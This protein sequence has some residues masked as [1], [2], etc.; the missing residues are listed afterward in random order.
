MTRH[1]GGEF[2]GNMLLIA[3]NVSFVVVATKIIA[4]IV[5][6]FRGRWRRMGIS[7]A[8]SGVAGLGGKGRACER[9]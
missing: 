4:R 9:A 7:I 3:S 2:W 5:C 1:R 6:E 8:D